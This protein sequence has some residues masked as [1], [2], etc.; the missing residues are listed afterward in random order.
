[1]RRVHFFLSM[2]A[3]VSAGC[4]T[5]A[6]T[7]HALPDLSVAS[8]SASG[9]ASAASGWSEVELD[10]PAPQ[11]Q[12]PLHPAETSIPGNRHVTLMVG[13]RSL[14]E[15]DWGSFDSPTVYGLEFDDTSSGS[16][17]GFEAGFFYTTKED[18]DVVAGIAGDVEVNTYEF[19]GGVRHVFR[20]GRR[21][22]HPFVSGG[23]DLLHG[24]I[25]VTAPGVSEAEGDLVGGAYARAGLLWDITDRVRLG[26]DYRYLLAQK[27][28]IFDD[29]LDT[30]YGQVTF[31]LGFAF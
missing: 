4:A 22:L 7:V 25:K 2:A 31:S 9:E 16:G 8:L 20:P 18:D 21:G 14:D 19:Y 29:S 26:A 30:D 17:N 5:N 13:E 24:R 10:V 3:C 28:N 6:A 1:M 27:L 23:L 15:D 12:Q 11:D